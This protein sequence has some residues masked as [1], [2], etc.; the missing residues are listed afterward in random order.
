MSIIASYITREI[1]KYFAIILLVVM[2]IYLTVDFIERIDNFIEAGVPLQRAGYYFLS[3][4]P[5]I[6]IQITPVGVL[7]AVLI[8]FGLMG[9]NNEL[10]ALRS[11][12]ISLV[13]LVGPIARCGLAGTLLV[14]LLAEGIAPLTLSNANQIWL[15]EVK[16]QKLTKTQQQDIWLKATQAIIH[17]S[18][19]E[20]DTKTAKGI[21]FSRFDRQFNLEQRID[22]QEGIYRDGRWIFH[23]GIMQ[24]RQSDKDR[25]DISLFEDREVNL[26]I[27]PEDLEQVV[28]QTEEMGFFQLYRYVQKV[29]TE[30]YDA[31]HYKV[32]LQAK[33]AFP[34]ACIIMTLM[35]AGLAAG[36]KIGSG[37]AISIIYGIGIAFLYWIFHS[38]CMSLGY[39]G[40]LPP[41]I[42]AWA[43]NFISLCAAVFLLV[44]AD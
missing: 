22:A 25:M 28:P 4:L 11:S 43:V 44:N 26:G 16:G 9:K 17:I 8:T 19:Y 38:F 7:L 1:G 12:G 33:I 18:F 23:K 35:G 37:M 15:Q 3:K 5:L 2:G 13:S 36:G 29:E 40:K 21:T 42:G 10:V 41:F 31:T 24:Q 30:G 20:Q 6:L 39:A 14:F 34:M 27:T 32:D